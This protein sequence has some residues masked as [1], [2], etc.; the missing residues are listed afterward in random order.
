MSE[1]KT[2]TVI[3]R[4]HQGAEI[5]RYQGEVIGRG[6]TWICIFAIYTR[7]SSNAGYMHYEQGDR[8]TEW[9]Y[10]DRWYNVFRID[11]FRDG[12]LKGWY[13]NIT[14]PTEIDDQ[15]IASD[16]LELDVFVSPTRAILLLDEAD[17]AA[18]TLDPE[19]QAAVWEAVT[20]IRALVA[21]GSPPFDAL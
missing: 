21:S 19:E 11:S 9:F 16:D 8:F 15:I 3:K 2:I 4:D 13:C 17:Y 6:A 12:A 20:D 18:L 14:R 10:S 1:N 5:L 7:P